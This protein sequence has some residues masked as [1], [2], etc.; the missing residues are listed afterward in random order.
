MECAIIV[1]QPAEVVWEV[2]KHLKDAMSELELSAFELFDARESVAVALLQR[3]NVG[4]YQLHEKTAQNTVI[5][6]FHSN[7][8]QIPNLM[9]RLSLFSR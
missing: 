2:G 6:A 1:H 4:R 9:T 7:Q 3:R 5:T 8:N